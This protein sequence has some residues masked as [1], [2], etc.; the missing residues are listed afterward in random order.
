MPANGDPGG[1][2]LLDTHVWIWLVQGSERELG[3]VTRRRL[4]KAA[5][6]RALMVSI[7]S[8]WEVA[9]L[10]LAGRLQLAMTVDDWVE[11]ALTAPGIA[12]AE[13]SPSIA[14]DAARLLPGAQSDPVDRFLMATGRYLGATLVTRDR[15]ILDHAATIRLRTCDARL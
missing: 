2:L 15:R 9:M 11:R 6:Q 3:R 1:G 13:L 10:E 7:L 8:L 12:L 4:E 5:A 14:L